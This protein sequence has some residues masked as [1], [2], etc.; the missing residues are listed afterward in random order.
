MV[1]TADQVKSLREKTDAG[2]M[3]CKKALNESDGDFGKAVEILRK[4]GIASVAKREGREAKEG[5]VGIKLEGSKGAIFELNCET[6][7]VAKTPAFQNLLSECLNKVFESGAGVLE[8]EPFT[9]SVMETSAKTGEK[10]QARRA[11]VLE[12]QNGFIAS[13]LHSNHRVGALVEFEG[14]S[15]QELGREVAMQVAAMKPL[16]VERSEV[17]AEWVAK[18]KEILLEQ[19]KEALQNKPE[20][21]Q[22]KIIEGKLGKRFEEICLLEQKYIKDDK[23]TVSR[24]IE[25]SNKKT[26]ASVKVKSFARYELGSN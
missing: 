21:V 4:K 25:A 7:F 24:L 16:Y 15:D 23:Q 13:Y 8:E 10:L 2:F 6:D 9:K 26:G 12:A 5:L 22:Q 18:E 11:C 17:P 1:V 14:G 20:A 3:D 19:S